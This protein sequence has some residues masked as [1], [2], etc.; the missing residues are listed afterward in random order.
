MPTGPAAAALPMMTRNSVSAI[1][2]TVPNAAATPVMAPPT[3]IEYS[4]NAPNTCQGWPVERAEDAV[5]VQRHAARQQRRV[6]GEC[7]RAQRQRRRVAHAS[8]QAPEDRGTHRRTD[9]DEDDG[10]EHDRARRV[11]GRCRRDVLDSRG[12]PRIRGDR[13]ADG[14]GGTGHASSAATGHVNLHLAGGRRRRMPRRPRVHRPVGARQ[15]RPRPRLPPA[16]RGRGFRRPTDA[17]PATATV[18]WCSVGLANAPE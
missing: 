11:A 3:A 17:G 9:R 16:R 15:R 12:Q 18:R 6:T 8:H 4:H 1:E 5:D 10:V 2:A 7:H 14:F 13:A